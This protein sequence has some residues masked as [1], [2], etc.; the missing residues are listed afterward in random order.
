MTSTAWPVM[1]VTPVIAM[2]VFVYKVQMMMIAMWE[3]CID[4]ENPFVIRRLV[5]RLAMLFVMN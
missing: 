2:E 4:L 5:K 3:R 1:E